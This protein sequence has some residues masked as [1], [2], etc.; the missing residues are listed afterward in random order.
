MLYL[1]PFQPSGTITLT[2]E[3]GPVAWSISQTDGPTGVL[4]ISPAAGLL[5]EG[6]SVQVTVTAESAMRFSADLMVNPGGQTVTVVYHVGHGS[7]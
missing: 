3:N 5:A 1:T 7:Y 6:Q 4:V 2:A